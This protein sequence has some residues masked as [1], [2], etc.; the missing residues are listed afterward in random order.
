MVP[1]PLKLPME[2]KRKSSENGHLCIIETQDLEDFW[3][4]LGT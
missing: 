3:A 2:L 1:T 4:P